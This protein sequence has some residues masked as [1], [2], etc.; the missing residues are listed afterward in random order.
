MYLR[1][2][3]FIPGH[4]PDFLQKIDMLPADGFV[5]DLEDAVSAAS[6]KQAT[7]IVFDYLAGRTA[8][9]LKPIFLRVN[10]IDSATFPEEKE[11]F[12][13]F[14]N[15][16]AIFP[17]V[18]GPDDFMIRKAEFGLRPDS[19]CIALIEDP[20][21]LASAGALVRDCHPDG[22]ALGLEDFFSRSIH[23]HDQLDALAAAIRTRI[24][25]AAISG[26]I[27]CF[28]TISLDLEGG[29]CFLQDCCQAKSCGMTGKFTIHP[30]Q[31]V[32]C[33]K[34]YGV[35]T[36][37]WEEAKAIADHF[38][39]A[40]PCGYVPWRGKLLSPPKVAKAIFTATHIN[41]IPT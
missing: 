4:R 33:N 10:P 14:P 35:E 9:G 34:V 41:E 29:E 17:K 2:L 11:L 37:Q 22:L 13:H 12:E 32:P 39:A 40:P 15:I 25:L 18:I 36:E 7:K 31:I 16:G 8:W 28:D 23:Q 26:D 38:G 27:P 30:R 3:H 20:A 19:A 1:S 6:K 24:A 21:G 5:I